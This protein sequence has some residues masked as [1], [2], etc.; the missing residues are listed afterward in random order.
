VTVRPHR[1][2]PLLDLTRTDAETTR[3]LEAAFQRVLQSG[4]FILGPEVA[5]FERECAAYLGA[6]HALGVS[7]GTDALIVALMALGIGPGD[8]VICPTYTFFATAGSIWRVGA[9]PVFV[10]CDPST[11]NADPD[12]VARKISPRTKAIVP[13]HLFGQC[14][15][16]APLS[17]LAKEKGIPLIEDAAQ[18]IG[19]RCGAEAAGTLGSIGCFSFFP[20]KNLGGFGDA[21]L[22]VTSDDA[23]AEKMGILRAHGA[24]PKYHHR[25]VGGNFRLD[26]LQAALLRVKL[27]RVERYTAA[28]RHNAARY[29]EL[30]VGL[31]GIRVPEARVPGHVYNQFV[32]RV[33]GEG[34]RDRLQAFLQQ[35]GVGTEVYYPVPMHRQECFAELGY[36]EGDLPTAER[37][38]RETLAIPVFPELLEEELAY[39]VEQVREFATEPGATG[40]R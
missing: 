8:E 21:G 24:K 32:L 35:R 23:L 19:A 3:E 7:S 25:V 11:Y 33:E 26:A 2:V 31:P 22:V 34:R 15:E 1:D 36:H 5:A 9:R 12:D 16:M 40:S 10:D 37:A 39:V 28:R 38:A 14:A 4:H 6:S 20:S 17:A 13:V 30:L 18:A 27:A 29:A